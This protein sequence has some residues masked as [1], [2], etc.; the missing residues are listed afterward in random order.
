MADAHPDTRSSKTLVGGPVFEC[1]EQGVGR[2]FIWTDMA[3]ERQM[4]PVQPPDLRFG[5]GVRIIPLFG[6][7]FRALLRLRAHPGAV[8][9]G[10][11]A[12]AAAKG[13]SESFMILE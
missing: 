7:R 1:V 10:R 9:A 2:L 11:H 3:D 8:A 5:N 12:E 4:R 13:A 6:R